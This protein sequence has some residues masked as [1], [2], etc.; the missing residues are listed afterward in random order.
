MTTYSYG[1]TTVYVN[2]KSLKVTHSG[3]MGDNLQSVIDNFNCIKQLKGWH[4]YKM[5]KESGS[6]DYQYI[7]TL[8]MRN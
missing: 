8:A 4:N 5:L 1:F 6:P 2:K 7:A 3:N